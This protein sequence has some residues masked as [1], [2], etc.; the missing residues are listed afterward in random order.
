MALDGTLEAS[1]IVAQGEVTVSGA[2]TVAGDFTVAYGTIDLER[3][4]VAVGGRFDSQGGFV[5]GSGEIDGNLTNAGWLSI[6][7]LTI[8]GD[9]TQTA[10]GRLSVRLRS[11]SDFDQLVVTGFA[12][13]DGTLDTSLANGYQPQAGDQLQVIEFG[14]GTGAFSHL[15]GNA[16]LFGVL[17]VY[18]PRP[19]VQPGVTLLF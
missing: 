5:F 3:G 16:P 2:L 17:Y 10:S 15:T 4:T 18:S 13:L 12:T 14:A 9:Y 1:S 6:G 11:A 19:D 7:S 8:N